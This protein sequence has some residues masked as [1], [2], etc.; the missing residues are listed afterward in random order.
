[1]HSWELVTMPIEPTQQIAAAGSRISELIRRSDLTTPAVRLGRWRVRDVVAH[2]GGVHRW[3]TRIVVNRS[4]DGPGF[5]KSKL[6][7]VELCDWFDEGVAELVAA[8][9]TNDP[10]G[11]CPNFNPGSAKTVSWW[12]RRQMHETIVH[13]WDVENALECTTPIAADVSVDCIDE[14]LDV[15]VR[16]RGKQTLTAPLVISVT[17]PPR[18][19]TLVPADRPGRL[20]IFA[21][22]SGRSTT[23]MS[24]DAEAL[25]LSLWRRQTL[26]EADLQIDGDPAVALSLFG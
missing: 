14:Y 7:G 22:N 3:A 12:E 23:A 10:D 5:T 26:E 8:F 20:D 4:M 21:G 1:M 11:P 19:W 16:T 25:L 17:E 24:G 2:L 9:E 6:D 15:F 18:S 13:R